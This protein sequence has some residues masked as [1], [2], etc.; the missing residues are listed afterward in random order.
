MIVLINA[1]KRIPSQPELD[2]MAEWCGTDNW[3]QTTLGAGDANFARIHYEKFS[4]K[5]HSAV[6]KIIDEMRDEVAKE[7]M[8]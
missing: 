7:L 1:G 2:R 4:E 5:V 3:G 8:R 6:L